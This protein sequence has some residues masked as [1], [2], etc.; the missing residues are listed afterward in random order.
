[1]RLS[2]AGLHLIASFEGFVPV[3][4]ADSAGNATVGYGHLLH[5]GPVTEAD[6]QHW[7]NATPAT[8]LTLL[9]AD[10]AWYANAVTKLVR[11]SLGVYPSRAQARF[12][13]LV[14]L[15]FNIGVGG[16]G[17]S[18]LLREI[19]RKGAPRDW[20]PCGPL[21]VEWSYAGGTV[22]PGLLARRQREFAIFRD[23]VYPKT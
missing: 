6:R 22:V 1:M 15:C 4:Y 11:V 8:L 3:P 5:V 21:W 13:A 9:Q 18:S 16:F 23:G 14:S 10:V 7:R 12:D 20:T 2:P 19:N 17:S